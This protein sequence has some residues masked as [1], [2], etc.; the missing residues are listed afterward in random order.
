MA[1]RFIHLIRHADTQSGKLF[2]NDFARELTPQGK[3]QAIQLGAYFSASKHNIQHIL[4]SPATRA[5]ETTELIAAHAG[6]SLEN[7]YFHKEI[8]QSNMEDIL[9]LLNAL[10]VTVTHAALV[11][12]F[13]TVVE[14]H[15]FLSPSKKSAMQ[16]CEMHTIAVEGLWSEIHAECGTTISSY[17]PEFEQ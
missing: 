3:L 17:R 10:P 14:L 9:Y 1:K 11:G 12:H 8:Y 13:P 5:K 7:I 15:D 4:S 6:C 2:S 16:T